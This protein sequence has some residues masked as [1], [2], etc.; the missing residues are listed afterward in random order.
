LKRVGRAAAPHLFGSR[1]KGILLGVIGECCRQ[2]SLSQKVS[3]IGAGRKVRAGQ[4][5]VMANGHLPHL[6]GSRPKGILLGV[7]GERCR[8]V[9]LPQKV[10]QIGAGRESATENTQP[11]TYF[12]NLY[13]AASVSERYIVLNFQSRCGAMVKW[14]GKSAPRHRRRCRQGKPHRL[15]DQVC[16]QFSP[17]ARRP[18]AVSAGG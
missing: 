8:Q 16:R 15:Q 17:D 18:T 7:I 1:P 2:V 3:Q 10:S 4:G 12:E 14:C 11:R 6:F 5:T 9:S 13:R